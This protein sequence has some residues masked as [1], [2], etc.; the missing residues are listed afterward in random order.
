MAV[1]RFV[2]RV[3]G[4]VAKSD[5]PA[6]TCVKLSGTGDEIEK[7]TSADD[8]VIG[9]SPEWE[10]KAKQTADIILLGGS[11]VDVGATSVPLGARLG[12]G[13]DG[14]AVAAADGKPV[15]GIATSAGPANGSC[16]FVTALGTR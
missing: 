8:L 2:V 1:Q 7:C 3:A 4:F 11:I 5:I 12:T 9:V 6:R 13:T 15:F 16:F 10:T 14:K